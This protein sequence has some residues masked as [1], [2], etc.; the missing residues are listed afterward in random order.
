MQDEEITLLIQA[1]AE[2][3]PQF[4]SDLRGTIAMLISETISFRDKLFRDTGTA[5][6][7]GDAREA[8][9]GL[10]HYLGGGTIPRTLSEQQ[11]ALLQLYI[12]RLTIFKR[13]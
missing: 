11:S 6:T 4:R 8:L 12:D 7:V 10:E 3:V 1:L 5:L 2:H 9:D 13:S